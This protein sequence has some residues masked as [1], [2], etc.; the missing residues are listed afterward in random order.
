MTKAED[1]Y[2]SLAAQLDTAIILINTGLANALAV[3]PFT[4]ASDPLFSQ[5]GPNMVAWK[6]FA[7][8]VKLRMM[9]RAGG[10]VTF[11]NTTF[12]SDGFLT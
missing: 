9:V 8:T 2:K 3:T 5:G 10:K 12:S 7:N 4:L 1:I 6:Q 11:A